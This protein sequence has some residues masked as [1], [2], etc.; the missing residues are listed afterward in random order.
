ME[1]EVRVMDRQV[2]MGSRYIYRLAGESG[3]LDETM[4]LVV[5]VTRAKLG[6]NYPNP[7]NPVTRI[8]YW[9][10]GGAAQSRVDLV[11][12][13]VRGAR[14]RTLVAGEKVSGRYAVDW[15]GR[16]NDG[17]PVSSGVYFYRMTAGSF[18]DTRRMVLL[19]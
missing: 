16:N 18:A 7:F 6:Q 15:D 8:E 12:Y 11:I 3:L 9:V 17:T 2:E 10:P 5:P 19:K 14:V 1:G 4:T 13:D